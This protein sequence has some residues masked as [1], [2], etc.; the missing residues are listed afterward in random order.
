MKVNRKHRIYWSVLTV[1]LVA[2][3]LLT[4]CAGEEGATKVENKNPGTFVYATIGPPDSLDPA[5]AYD[6]ASGEIIQSIYET[7]I[8]YD[9]VSATE[10]VPMLA[11]EWNISPDGKTYRFKIREGVKFHN[12][13]D[14]TPEDVEYSIE[15]GMVQDYGA[16]PQWMFF[17]PLFGIGVMSSRTEDGLIPLDEIKSKVE[18][19]GQ[20]VQFNLAGPYEP[21]LQILANT[22]GSIVDKEWCVANGDWDGTQQSYE[23]LNDPPSGGSPLNAIMNGTGPFKLERWEPGVETSLVRNDDY[24]QEPAKL[25]RVVFKVIDEWTTRKLMLE[26]GDA[27]CVDVPRAYI[28][29]LEGVS[30]LTVY[31]DLPQLT[32]DAFFFQFAI[33]PESTFVSSGQLDGKGI[34]LDFFTDINVRKG[35]AY[36]FDWEVYLEDAMKGEAQQVGSP[37][38]EGLSYYDPDA[39]RYTKDLEKSAEYFKQAWGGEVW[40]KGFTFTIAYNAG[41]IPRKTACEILQENL[42]AVNPKFTVL[43]QVMQWPTL[44]RSMY[45]GLIPMFQI[46]W[47]ADYADAH[48]FIAPFMS[49]NGLF[50][51]WQNYSNPEVDELISEAISAATSAE[52]ES[53]Y[54]QLDQLYIDEVPS[55]IIDQPL[56]RRY[57]RDWVK[58]WYFNP[59]L[60]SQLGYIYALSKK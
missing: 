58:G 20:W 1:V 40:E 57:F 51:A 10:F 60:P 38:V 47:L 23:A 24:W 18:V 41:N 49:S 14:M 46:G 29:E 8:F 15:R 26:A 36:A 43:I 5:Y 9:G 37:I 27:D 56:G 39:P 35:I 16:G 52:R 44:L 28:D 3:A 48:N 21:F 4:S 55:F 45:S 31:K 13:N 42:L 34:P 2:A 19:D 22:W 7:L 50:S 11:T 12:G 53:I 33:N 25:E 6:T 59:V 32:N 30:G 17:E 54:R